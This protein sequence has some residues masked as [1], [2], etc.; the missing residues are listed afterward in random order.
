[1]L[2]TNGRTFEL[3]GKPFFWLGDTCWMMFARMTPEEQKMYLH[4][5]HL[6]GFNVVQ[7]TLVH[8]PEYTDRQGHRALLD[9]DFARP[10]EADGYWDQVEETVRRAAEEKIVLA[11]VL[12]WGDFYKE[13]KMTP[14]GGEA[15]ARFLAGRF[16]KYENII[17][18]LGGDVRGSVCPDTF[19]LIG[20]TLKENTPDQ[21]VGYHPFGRTSSANWF[22]GESWLDFHMVQSGHRD[23]SQRVLG[24]WDD[25][26]VADEEWM[27]EENYRYIWRDRERDTKPVVDGEPSYEE[28]PHGLHD[29]SKPYWTARE[30]RRYAWWDALA[31]CAGFTYGHNS[32]MQVWCGIGK[33]QFGVRRFWKEALAGEAA[34][35]MRFLKST[36]E[37]ADFAHARSAQDLLLE[38]DGEEDHFLVALEGPDCL[39][40]YSF[41]GDPVHVAA[42]R[43]SF[44]PARAY[45]LNP[46]N[47]SLT[48]LPPA[49]DG[50]Y[51]PPTGEGLQDFVL[52]LAGDTA[53]ARFEDP[54]LQFGL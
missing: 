23:R 6:Q 36:M 39:L 11:L 15:F 51:S 14:E 33:P 29:P 24:A 52:I 10:D 5:R 25:N 45:W 28:I 21:P 46:S 40:V 12:C 16:G 19:R 2:K 26:G 34:G 47:G 43:L 18:L 35:Q 20:R 17:W 49:S 4:V 54:D 30:V 44:M 32:V 1:M 48:F 13:G 41:L 38:N 8:E 37:K 9:E 7:A 53:A 31:G 50:K 3:D 42:D 22:A 27:A